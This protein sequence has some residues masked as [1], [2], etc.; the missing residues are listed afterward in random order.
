M[1]KNTGFTLVEIV[2]VCAIIAILLAVGLP[3]YFRS[4]EIAKCQQATNTLKTLSDGA[5]DFYAENDTFA[6][7]S[8]AAINA[9]SGISIVNNAD[10]AYVAAPTGAMGT[11]FLLTSTRLRGPHQTDGNT[12]ILLDQDYV[13][14]GTYPYTDPGNF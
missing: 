14:A 8:V 4:T 13:W 10:W 12:T 2:V 9:Q 5:F 7:L 1:H 3:S 6:G 11:G